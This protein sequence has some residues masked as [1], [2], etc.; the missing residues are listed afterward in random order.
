MV[1]CRYTI[2]Q[3]LSSLVISS[4]AHCGGPHW[5]FKSTHLTRS[6]DLAD[7]GLSCKPALTV[8]L[9]PQIVDVCFGHPWLPNWLCAQALDLNRTVASHWTV[10]AKWA[11]VAP[12]IATAHRRWAILVLHNWPGIYNFLNYYRYAIACLEDN[13]NLMYL[14]LKNRKPIQIGAQ[15]RRVEKRV[16]KDE[17]RLIHDRFKSYI[18]Y[19]PQ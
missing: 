12:V 9:I 10:M 4:A 13:L 15:L 18:Q 17:A 5:R 16:K 7:D 6:V 1:Q 11:I 8:S 19:G 2:Y 3:L 14:N